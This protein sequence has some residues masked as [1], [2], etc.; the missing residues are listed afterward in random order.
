MTVS[1]EDRLAK[2]HAAALLEFDEIQMALRDERMQCLED[3]RFYSISGAQWEGP[4]GDQ[5]EN[6]PRFEMNKVHLA[7]IR[8]INEY[9]NN[10]ITVDFSPKDGTTGDKM[11]DVCDGLYRADEQDSTAEEAYDNAFEEAVG[12][13]FGAWRLRACY[14]NEDDDDDTRQRIKLE[15]IFDADS[16][17]FFD[18]NAKRQDK[19]D[20]KR[21]YVLTGMTHAAYKEEYGDDPA[22]WPKEIKSTFFDWCTPSVVYVCEHYRIEEKTELIHVFRGLDE[23]DMTVPDQELQDD[24]DKLQVLLATGFREVRQKR[25]KRREVQ[26]YV[27]S[28]SKALKDKEIIPGR[29]IPVIPTY[30]KRWY[31]DNVE[32]CMG[33]VRLAKDAQ[34]LANMLR[35]N[36]GELA[37]ESNT[38]KPIF[39]PQQIAG[40]T[41]MW[42]EDNVKKYPYLLVNPITDANG[43]QQ[44]AG[45]IGYTKAPAVPEAWA[46]LMQVVE[47]DMQALLGN[48]Q[49]GE[50]MQPNLSGK[51]VELIQNRLDMQVF[52]YMSNFAK[53]MRRSGQVWLSMS[54]DILVE[55]KRRMK[56]IDAS[57]EVGSVVVNEPSYDTEK[58]EEIVENDMTKADF[59]VNV[60]VGPSSSSRRA[61]TVRALTG[62][63][64]ITQDPE[65]LSVLSAMTLMNMEG[66]GLSE[67]RDFFRSK[68][69]KMGVIKPTEEEAAELAAAAQNAKPDPQAQYLQ[70]A[71]EEATA[72]AAS[73]RADTMETI[74]SADLKRAQTAKTMAETMGEHN[75]QEI[76]SAQALQ[77]MLAA[78]AGATTLNIPSPD[79]G[80]PQ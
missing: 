10:R 70:A 51:A 74:A 31:V 26:K 42:A 38:E 24:P 48:Q 76:A 50:Q 27:M 30:G 40:H 61:A 71:A 4:I 63:M 19:A 56:T 47:Q 52:I 58:A 1:K 25:V 80:L 36:L 37:G 6:K 22:S 20:A 65:T 35:S 17:V 21:C 13:G 23:E 78:P 66:E 2:V 29:C 39:T 68:M 32:R 34:R 16:S 49:A 75:Q 41:M 46:A 69:V 57:G 14:E 62:M 7:V 12:G 8:I 18:L 11:A 60:D 15:P 5:F 77:E 3:R 45:P 33:H 72:G 64:S 79:L 55:E 53:A 67:T 43:Q 28:G 54:K 44:A 73:K 9:R 59:D